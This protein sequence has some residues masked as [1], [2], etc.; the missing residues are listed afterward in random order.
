[1]RSKNTVVNIGNNEYKHACESLLFPIAR[2][3]KPDLILISCGFDSAIHDPLGW[4]KVT[5]IMYF[6]M[7]QELLKIC[8]R[9][10]VCQEGGY[11]TDF[12]GQHA[13][14][15]VKALLHLADYGETTQ[16]D[17]DGG[18]HKVDEIDSSK[19]TK[20]AFDDVEKTREALKAFW[21]EI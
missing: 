4:I 10:L 20:Q 16:A 7:T 2:Q 9:L 13:S 19:C 6:W 21:K 17:R 3:F 8:P 18:F 5:P 12:L 14:G 11:N 15:V 1:M